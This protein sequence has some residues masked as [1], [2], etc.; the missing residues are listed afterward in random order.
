MKIVRLT[1]ALDESDF[2]KLDKVLYTLSQ[3]GVRVSRSFVVR[4]LLRTMPEGGKLLKAVE[5]LRKHAPD[6]RK[7]KPRR[8]A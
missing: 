5:E 4:A 6:G 8:R 1:V 3:Q 7:E 2:R